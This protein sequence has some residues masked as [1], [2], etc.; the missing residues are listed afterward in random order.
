MYDIPTCL[1]LGDYDNKDVEA[2]AMEAASR[3]SR[4]VQMLDSEWQR[5]DKDV[6]LWQTFLD[7][8]HSV[9]ELRGL[10]IVRSRGKCGTRPHSQRH[11]FE[12]SR[13]NSETRDYKYAICCANC[14]ISA[15]F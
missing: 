12:A 1:S 15:H 7:D 5:L 9:C 13:C 6:D 10:H 3:I 8:I 2:S 11:D 14:E 4:E